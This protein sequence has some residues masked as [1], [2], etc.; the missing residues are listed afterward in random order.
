MVC[1]TSG[2][3]IDLTST[4][5]PALKSWAGQPAVL[6]LFDITEDEGVVSFT[7]GKNLYQSVIEDFEAIDLTGDAT[8]IRGV[9][10]NWNLSG[11][12][13]VNVAEAGF[14]N[15]QHVLTLGRSGSITSSQPFAKGI[16]TMKFT[17]NNG[18]YQI[19]FGLKVSTD[20]GST[21]EYFESETTM[22]KNASQTFEFFS[23]PAGAQIQL[24]MRS[25]S[26]SA[27]CYIDD[28]ECTF[29][30]NDIPSAITAVKADAETT[31][32]GTYNLAG[33]RVN[34][35]YHGIVIVDG[36]KTIRR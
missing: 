13:V 19:R 4:T 34:D 22:K 6:D 23:I 8:D 5:T 16:R 9:F 12:S 20:G 24:L 1:C 32:K 29:V 21:W 17:V 26:T 14:G 28:I 18:G 2:N 25:T 30:D 36:K 11:A 35:N 7:A 27:V 33:Q 3:P 10:C 31:A 15:G